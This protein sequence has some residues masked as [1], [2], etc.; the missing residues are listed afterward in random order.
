[1]TIGEI[2]IRAKEVLAYSGVPEPEADAE[3]LLAHVIGMNRLGM[4]L[5]KT[6]DISLPEE[7][8]L[9]KMIGERVTRKPVQYI[10]GEHEFW[11][12]TFK[13]SQDVLIPRPETEILIEV[14]LNTLGV[15]GKPHGS[16]KVLDLCTGTGILAVVLAKEF[17]GSLVYAVDVSE[18]ALAVARENAGRHGV[19]DR[20]TFLEGDL[21]GPVLD[22]K[23]YFDVI[24]SNPP[25]V[26]RDILC[27]LMPEVRDFEPRLALDGGPEGL[28]ILRRIVHVAGEY[29]KRDGWVFLEIGYGQGKEVPG[30]IQKSGR[31]H[32]LR[33]IPDYSG[34]ER[35]IQAQRI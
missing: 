28:C 7:E 17:P 27:D 25:Y 19:S 20:I 1:M 4:L 29:L 9:E 11:S 8:R 34:I 10:I 5:Q 33:V 12:L 31:F 18:R 32:N 14:A 26:P 2:L 15:S 6:R 16:L 23:E 24:V 22:K 30:E 35:I 13:V 21:F 3:V